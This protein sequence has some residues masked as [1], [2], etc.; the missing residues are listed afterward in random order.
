MSVPQ[1]V[2][3]SALAAIIALALIALFFRLLRPA[4]TRPKPRLVEPISSENRDA[5]E[6]KPLTAANKRALLIEGLPEADVDYVEDG[7]TLF[8]VRGWSR[9]KI[10]LACIDCPEGKQPWGDIAKYGLLK[11]VGRRKVRIEEHGLDVY[12]RTL[13]TIYV[14]DKKSAEWLNVN[15]RMVMLGHAWVLRG[16]RDNLP[17]D[18]QAKLNR[19][20]DWAKSKKVGLWKTED[21]IPPWQWRQT[22][23]VNRPPD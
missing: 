16:F 18:R 8:V 9:T 2:L 3:H 20:E 23:G 5:I 22:R 10:R 14:R 1:F 6:R 11:M 19:L 12:G 15:E 4:P 7:D 21:P 13:A 17:M